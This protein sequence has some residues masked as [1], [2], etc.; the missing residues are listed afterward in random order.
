MIIFRARYLL[1]IGAPPLEDGALLVE[2]GRIVAVGP[3]RELAAAHPRAAAVVFEDATILP[4]LANAHTHLELSAF[5]EWCGAWQ[6]QPEPGDFVGWIEHLI[7]VKSKLPR[8]SYAPAIR[9]GISALLRSGCAAVGDILSSHQDCEVFRD[10]PLFGRVYFEILGLDSERLRQQLAGLDQLCAAAP[11]GRLSPGISPH[12]PYTLAPQL[13]DEVLAQARLRGWAVSMH[14]GES[15]DEVDFLTGASGDIAGRLYPY[16]GWQGRVPPPAGLR[17]VPYL[18]QRMPLPLPFL[19]AHGIQVT[20]QEVAAIKAAGTGV[21]LCPRSNARLGVGKAPVSTYHRSGVPLALG[22]DSL[23]SSPSLSI[24]E[25]MA[26]ARNWFAGALDPATWLEI[27]TAG[28][29]A[30]RVR[31]PMSLSLSSPKN[32][33]LP[34]IGS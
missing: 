8:E 9:S 29:A 32:S 6:D 5:P 24:W 3:F 31:S 12:S 10:C 1:P 34:A 7:K 20:A 23:A 30:V 11:F 26:F 28:G 2:G 15:P 19:L 13:L 4:P 25:E 33:S 22:T 16:V 14:L 17:P 27:A 18:M 21:V